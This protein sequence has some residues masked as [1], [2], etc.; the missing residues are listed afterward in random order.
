MNE[1]APR[2]GPRPLPLHAFAAWRANLLA[3]S[4]ASGLDLLDASTGSK[5]RKASASTD[6]RLRLA[7]A[8]QQETSRRWNG[9][10]EGVGR[11]NAHPYRR[12]LSNQPIFWQAGQARVT[13]F[14]P[15]AHGLPVIAVPSLVNSSDVLDLLPGRSLM[16]ALAEAGF[17]P[18]LVEWN[19]PEA[20]PGAWTIDRYV[21]DRLRPIIAAV[22]ERTGRPP[23]VIGYCM[24]GLLATALAAHAPD[25]I[26]GLA[27]LATPWDFHAPNTKNARML[28]SMAGLFRQ[29]AAS[30]GAVPAEL[31]QAMFFMLDPTLAARKYRAFARQD[32]SAPAAEL[33]VAMEDWV[34]S[35]P[36]L[37]A[38][39]AETVLTQWYGENAI[40]NERWR[41]SGRLVNAESFA[42]P[43]LIA[44]PTRDRIVPKA[45]AE[46][47]AAHS[48]HAHLLN[49]DAGHVGMIIGE[50]AKAALWTPLIDWLHA[51]D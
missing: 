6:G 50:R 21:D 30:T 1:P 34:N 8:L 47:Y 32:Q 9:F 5:V 7:M 35:G 33:F 45:S 23:A 3:L 16:A 19:G 46:A 27:L 29:S 25:R 2:F 42:G 37:A 13:D 44:V 49:V 17:H 4:A 26:A 10:W 11:Y 48:E 51:L 14:A 40:M 36:P 38:P 41:V 24:G 20:E 39:V 43:T 15:E 28:A 31:L 12:G 22:G 18:L